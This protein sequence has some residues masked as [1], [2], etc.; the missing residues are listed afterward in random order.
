MAKRAANAGDSEWVSPLEDEQAQDRVKVAEV[1]VEE[2]IPNTVQ[3]VSLRDGI[4]NVT[5]KSTGNVYRFVGAGS[6]VDVDDRDAT[7]ILAKRSGRS[8]CGPGFT[9]FFALKQ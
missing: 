1:P 4:V 7:E 2:Y 9:P 8:C 5:G 3:I 6:A